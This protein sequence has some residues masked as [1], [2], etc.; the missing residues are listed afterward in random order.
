MELIVLIVSVVLIAVTAGI[1]RLAA[2]L[3]ER[4]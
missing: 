3:Q 2:S 4:K 1:Y